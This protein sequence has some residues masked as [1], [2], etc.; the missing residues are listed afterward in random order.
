LISPRKALGLGLS[1]ARQRPRLVLG[2]FAIDLVLSYFATW[3]FHETFSA[4][5]EMRPFADPLA[6]GTK[7]DILSEIF[8]RRPDIMTAGQAGAAAA[9]FAWIV[10]NWFLIAGVIGLLREPPEGANL[11]RFGA[12]AAAHGFAMMRLQL[13]SLVF[14]AVA[15]IVVALG[16]TLGWVVGEKMV[17]PWWTLILSGLF[18]LPGLFLMLVVGT[19]VDIARVR[20]VTSGNRAMLSMLAWGLGVVRRHPRETLGVQF[21]GGLLWAAIGAVY[22]LIAWP[23]PYATGVAFAFL[24]LLRELTVLLRTGVRVGTLGGILELVREAAP[25]AASAELVPAPARVE[26]PELEMTKPDPVT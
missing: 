2:I 1:A 4:A 15:G 10:L 5:T 8:A 16:A 22:L 14:Y 23:W 24:T 12:E 13:W 26:Q 3:P 9:T 18:C 21:L 6:S 11:R 17:N 19:A 25:S 20:T 7:L